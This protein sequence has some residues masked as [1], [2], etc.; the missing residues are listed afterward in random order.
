M[1]VDPNQLSQDK[2]FLGMSPQDQT[3]Y[4]SSQDPDFAK[5]APADQ[6]G[7]INH[8]TGKPVQTPLV[9]KPQIP[10]ESSASDTILGALSPESLLGIG[11]GPNT[12]NIPA[13]T[14]A[15]PIQSGSLFRTLLQAPVVAPTFTSPRPADVGNVAKPLL[16]GTGSAVAP[17]L[18]PEMGLGGSLLSR[19][20]PWLARAA[21]SGGGTAAGTILGQAA[22]GQNPLETPQLKET[23]QNA[24]LAGGSELA[25]GALPLLGGAKLGRG[26]INAS[27]GAT[28]RDVI[29]GN[30]AKAL[31]NEGI[32]TPVTG[33]IELFKQAMRSGAS[34]S[35]AL[36]AAGGRA[37][38]ISQR[39]NQLAPQL[40]AALQGSN[41]TIS[42]AQTIDRPLN[43]AAAAIINNRAM[44]ETEKDAAINQIGALQ[45]AL[46]ENLPANITSLQ[47]NQIK[48]A[49]GD[50]VNWGGN[51]AVGDEIKPAYRAVYGA[52][53]NAVNK[54]VPETAGINERLTD[55]LAAQS[56]VKKLMGVEEVGFGKGVM[57]SAVT[58]IARR[59][60][61]IGGRAIPAASALGRG[62]QTIVPAALAAGHSAFAPVPPVLRRAVDNS[63]FMPVPPMLRRAVTPPKE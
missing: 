56:D 42:T 10:V 27:V 48:Q 7:Y 28:A 62:G 31:L 32:K 54:A 12:P 52:L 20:V 50:R 25:L 14:P 6:A 57:G 23:G 58:G 49:I 21:A 2:D 19:A 29:Y 11:K 43:D 24:A 1:G 33:D 51:I 30:P 34:P 17:E 37:G 53:K 41:S 39:I 5:M 38:A 22:T 45:K 36:V 59:L 8:L 46:K 55:L 26:M 3:G 61:A 60:E 63:A 4:L 18:L 9:P 44:T 15:P 35:D 40:D 13:P 47:A 16:I